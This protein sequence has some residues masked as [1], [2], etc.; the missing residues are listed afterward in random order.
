MGK[1]ICGLVIAGLLSAAAAS[2]A[3]VLESPAEGAALS[4][5]GFISG[6]KCD[7]KDITVTI[8]GG[9]TCLSL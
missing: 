9:D 8:D 2:N 7:G 5:L 4:G 6:W 3:A 1:T